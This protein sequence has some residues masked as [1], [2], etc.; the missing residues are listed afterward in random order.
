MAEA[1][2]AGEHGFRV[3]SD[4]E[5]PR[6]RASK[7]QDLRDG[8]T[9]FVPRTGDARETARTLSRLGSAGYAAGFL[10]RRR[11]HSLDEQAGH[12]VWWVPRPTEETPND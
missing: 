4:D 8:L 2:M 11:M 3:I 7:Y 9:V 10:I 6:R 5:R 12:V 1:A